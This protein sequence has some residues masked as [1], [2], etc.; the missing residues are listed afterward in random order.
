M[1]FISLHFT[2]HL[3]AIARA[4]VDVVVST[5]AGS[6]LRIGYQFTYAAILSGNALAGRP[7]RIHL[8]YAGRRPEPTLVSSSH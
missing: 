6:P 8:P 1:K 3:L 5:S 2:S 7:Q 4:R